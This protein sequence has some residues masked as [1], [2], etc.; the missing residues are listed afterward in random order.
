MGWTQGRGLESQEEE[1]P[2]T[3]PLTAREGRCGGG[4]EGVRSPL[5]EGQ[6]APWQELGQARL[7]GCPKSQ[8][9]TGVEWPISGLVPT[10]RCQEQQQLL[11]FGLARS[12]VA[13]ARAAEVRDKARHR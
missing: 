1:R 12:A 8:G 13:A 3:E 11:S 6:P 9:G 2:C 10:H 5:W 7:A 4:G